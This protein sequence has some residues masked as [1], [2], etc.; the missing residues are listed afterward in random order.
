MDIWK[1]PDV[2]I[3]HL[4]RFS[5]YGGMFQQKNNQKVNYP[6]EIDLK[7]WVLSEAD[8]ILLLLFFDGKRPV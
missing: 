7:K 8:V 2:C 6:L 3:V 4:K 5:S 1:I